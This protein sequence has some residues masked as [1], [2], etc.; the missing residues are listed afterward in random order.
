MRLIVALLLALIALAPVGAQTVRG[1]IV[2]ETTRLPVSAVLITLLGADGGEIL[3]GV[4]S[5]TLGGFAIHAAR[6]GTYRVRATRIGYRPLTSEAVALGLGQLAVV[7]LR[8]T[9]VAQQLVPIRVVERRQLTLTELMSTAGFDMRQGKGVGRFLNTEQLAEYGLEGAGEVLRTYLRPNVEIADSVAGAFLWMRRAAG[10]CAPEIYLDGSILS[11]PG[12]PIYRRQSAFAMLEAFAAN[13]LH[14]IEVYRGA[15]VPPPSLAGSMG[16]RD[17]SLTR[18]CGV[19]AVW[20]KKGRSRMGTAPRG[21]G[22]SGIQVVRGTVLDFD[23]GLPLAGVPVT[24]L[25]QTNTRLSGAVRSDSAGEFTIRTT[26][27]GPLRLEAG[28]IGHRAATTPVFPVGAEEL[29]IVKLFVSAKKPVEAPLGILARARPETHAITD[30]ASFAYRRERGIAGTFFGAEDIRRRG[31]TTLA[32]LL[33]GVDGV[34]V[35]GVAPSDAILMRSSVIGSQRHCAP[36]VFVDGTRLMSGVDSAVRSLAMGRIFGV[37]V[38]TTPSQV[39]PVHADA[40]DEC[41]MIGIWTRDR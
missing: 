4:R 24:L 36:T 27:V 2:D 10:E 25:S 16:G 33:R 17:T 7:R 3:P 26:R 30:L 12:D 6:P 40:V 38:Y 23:S 19:V 15:Q 20:T 28:D 34:V 13:E 8:M 14:G 1:S 31:V 37:E 32:E 39:P 5:D 29:I 41:G 11:E 22:L 9:T 35:A 21:A 18:P